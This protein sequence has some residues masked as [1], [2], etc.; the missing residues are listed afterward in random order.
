MTRP[1]AEVIGDPIAQSKSPLIHN[2]WLEKLG[3]DADYRATRVAI[4]ALP[5]Y[6]DSR[7][8]DPDWRGCNVTMPLKQ[9]V[10]P[11][12]DEIDAFAARAG[13]INTVVRDPAGLRGGNSDGAGFLEPL[14]AI[15]GKT[16]MAC[17]IG[18]GGAARGIAVALLDAG[19]KLDI[20]GRTVERAQALAEA[21]GG[22]GEIS[23]GAMSDPITWDHVAGRNSFKLLINATSLGMTGHPPLN[24]PLEGLAPDVA[25]YDI[26]TSP[27]ETPLLRQARAR[28]MRC[29][30]GLQMLVG[31]AAVAFERFFGQPAPREHDAELRARLVS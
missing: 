15:D 8:A 6:F 17:L 18:T 22:Q 13:A 30:D 26:V 3:I 19:F 1:Y 4:D 24:L 28:G 23:M 20:R 14:G 27:P 12:I 31:Q 16:A 11:L 7:R 9:A 2:F 29:F 10:A 25:V 5:A 21:V